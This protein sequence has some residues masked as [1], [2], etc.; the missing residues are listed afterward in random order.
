MTYPK[1]LIRWHPEPSTSALIADA[2]E[3]VLDAAARA[4]DAR[5]S[6]VIVLAG[7]TT[8]RAL[9]EQLRDAKTEWSLWHIWFG[10][11]R[12]A[13]PDDPERNSRMARTAWLDHV[14]IP[15]AQ[16]HQIPGELGAVEAARCYAAELADVSSFD[17]V[18]LG[19]GEDGHTASLFPGADAGRAPDSA[20]ALAVFDSPKPPPERVSLSARRLGNSRETVFLVS[21]ESKRDAVRRWRG[22]EKIPANMIVPQSGVDVLVDASLL[23]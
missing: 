8:P 23:S 18:L 15:A 17:L 22:G 11:E 7:G 19:L 12:C 5:G 4:L 10:D 21:G 3:R 2:K 9:Y 1:Q 6:F 13:S 14:A 16:V 20:S